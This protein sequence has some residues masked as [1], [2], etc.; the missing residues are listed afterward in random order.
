MYLKISTIEIGPIGT[1][2]NVMAARGYICVN[3]FATFCKVAIVNS[4]NCIYVNY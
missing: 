1:R 4:S 3:Y 2:P